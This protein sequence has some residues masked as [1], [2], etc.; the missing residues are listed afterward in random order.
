MLVG[1]W[2][3][4]GFCYKWL[5]LP[6]NICFP[7]DLFHAHGVF[8]W[9]G[10]PVEVGRLLTKRVISFYVMNTESPLSYTGMHLLWEA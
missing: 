2:E 8:S 5:I 4:A 3:A 9:E 10:T 7:V 6:V 1:V